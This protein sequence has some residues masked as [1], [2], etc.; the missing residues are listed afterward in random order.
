[1]RI[2]KEMPS[3]VSSYPTAEPNKCSELPLNAVIPQTRSADRRPLFFS[4]DTV[5][6]GDTTF[7]CGS[8]PCPRSRLST[9]SC[10]SLF[11]CQIQHVLKSS[12]SKIIL[13]SLL[14]QPHHFLLGL[15]LSEGQ[16]VPST[17]CPHPKLECPC[18]LLSFPH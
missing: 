18:R 5:S 16:T 10:T 14:P 17:R 15:Y 9:G 8:F 6:L 7:A 1:M 3:P 11:W 13:I 4:Y 2:M 12:M